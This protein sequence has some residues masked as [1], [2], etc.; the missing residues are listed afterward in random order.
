MK[1]VIA[2]LLSCA[3]LLPC[4]G[5]AVFAEEGSQ[6]ILE[7]E[8]DKQLITFADAR[9]F[10]EN[11]RTLVP[12]RALCVALGIADEN[13]T[14]ADGVVSIRGT[15]DGNDC[16]ISL[17]IGSPVAEVNGEKKELDVAAKIVDDRTFVPLRFASET[18]RCSVLFY[19]AT[20]LYGNRSLISIE[21][22][23][24]TRFRV[25]MPQ[26]LVDDN[27]GKLFDVAA[28]IT[29]VNEVLP[30]VGENDT[31]VEEIDF[32][33]ASGNWEL[34]V[35][36]GYITDEKMQSLA[37]EGLLAKLDQLIEKYAPETYQKIQES[38]ELKKLVCAEDGSIVAFPVERNGKTERVMVASGTNT[39]K[40]V[41]LIHGYNEVIKSLKE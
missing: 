36:N 32:A 30:I 3:L 6:G 17:T 29:G 26:T 31:A 25:Y 5:A 35:D 19:Q 18:F 4:F 14:F 21:T 2:L 16:T 11:D 13:V 27:V 24:F 39:E 10:I 7:V 41:A 28:A 20:P 37:S 12:I 22:P 1:K 38:D 15:A 33:V 40:A 23:S 8:V 34:I 9:P